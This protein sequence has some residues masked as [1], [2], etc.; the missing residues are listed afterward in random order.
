MLHSTPQ[1]ILGFKALLIFSDL[2]SVCV[3]TVFPCWALDANLGLFFSWA[4]GQ[5]IASVFAVV[6]QLVGKPSHVLGW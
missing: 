5:V 2:V 4:A 1:N 6:W 3:I